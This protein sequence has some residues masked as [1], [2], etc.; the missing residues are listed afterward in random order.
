[1][2]SSRVTFE[3][4]AE[5]TQ[6]VLQEMTFEELVCLWLIV[7]MDQPHSFVA[8]MLDASSQNVSRWYRRALARYERALRSIKD[9]KKSRGNL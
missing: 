4:L 6:K 9:S 7:F 8:E 3:E 2:Q 5:A 1:M